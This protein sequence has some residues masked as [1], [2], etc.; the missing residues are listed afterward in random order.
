LVASGL[1]VACNAGSSEGISSKR[2]K[3]WNPPEVRVTSGQ[4]PNTTIIYIVL[5]TSVRLFQ[6]SSQRKSFLATPNVE[7]ER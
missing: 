3:R 4:K 6:I 5:Q 7:N 2:D 1:E